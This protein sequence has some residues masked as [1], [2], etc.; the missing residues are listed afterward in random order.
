MKQIFWSAELYPP[1]QARYSGTQVTELPTE[2]YQIFWPTEIHPA[3]WNKIFWS[4]ELNPLNKNRYS[5]HI[6][7]PT[8]P[9]KIFRCTNKVT[10]EPQIFEYIELS[11]ITKPDKMF[12]YTELHPLKQNR[13]SGKQ[14]AKH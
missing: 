13:Y 14:N 5:D 12:W 6:T 1:N 2:Q 9:D 8:K 3:N 7:T 10:S 11:T 4:T